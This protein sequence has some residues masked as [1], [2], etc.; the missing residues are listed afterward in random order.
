MIDF[1][2]LLKIEK[3]WNIFPLIEN[4]DLIDHYEIRRLLLNISN[5]RM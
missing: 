4:L 1:S 5:L 2:V 3:S